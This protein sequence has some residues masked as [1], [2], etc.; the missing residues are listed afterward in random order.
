[1]KKLIAIFAAVLLL[2]FVG[3]QNRTVLS[4]EADKIIY[5]SS[6]D[7]P[8]P[9]QIGTIDERFN[10]TRDQLSADIEEAGNIWSGSYGKKLFVYDPKAIMTVNLVYD[11][12]QSLNSQI[13]QIDS[14]LKD[15]DKVLKPEIA[16]YQTRSAEFRKKISALNEEIKHWNSQGGAPE[17]EYKK[18]INEQ[19]ALKQESNSLNAM[20]R[21][22]NQSTEAFNTQVQELGQTVDT[23]N[24]VLQYK[25]EEG[26]YVS[27][28]NGKRILIYFYT[29]KQEFLHTLAHEM[30]HA[31]GIEHIN[32]PQAIMFAKTNNITNPSEDDLASLAEVCRKRSLLELWQIKAGYIAT[33]LKQGMSNILNKR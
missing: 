33:A 11:E 10:I 2:T 14:K 32:N 25:P 26:L 20:A 7:E 6:C 4:N 17:E 15:Q 3:Y 22:L 31:L 13:T 18:L 16:E 24:S 9:Y 12:R 27:D 1:M 30:G 28:E 8:L 21:S 23:Y 29:N 5:H 19:E